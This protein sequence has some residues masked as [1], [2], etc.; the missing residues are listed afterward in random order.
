M[1]FWAEKSKGRYLACGYLSTSGQMGRRED[2][3]AEGYKRVKISVWKSS[4]RQ[5]IAI[6]LGTGGGNFFVGLASS[7]I[8]LKSD[9]YLHYRKEDLITLHYWSCSS[10]L[11]INFVFNCIYYVLISTN[12]IAYFKRSAVFL[13]MTNSFSYCIMISINQK[14]YFKRSALFL[15]THKSNRLIGQYN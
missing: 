3:D 1:C 7:R 6:G 15:T 4:S 12:Q 9:L 11:C 8:W 13:K 5:T 14:A 2:A 10:E